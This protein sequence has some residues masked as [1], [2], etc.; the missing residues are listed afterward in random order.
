[1]SLRKLDPR[2]ILVLCFHTKKH[3]RSELQTHSLRTIDS[4]IFP[5]ILTPQPML[6]S[7]IELSL[8]QERRVVIAPEVGLEKQAHSVVKFAAIG[9]AQ[10]TTTS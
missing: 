2:N 9:V 3:V 4:L 8:K 5:H 6:P 7:R 1:M 10:N